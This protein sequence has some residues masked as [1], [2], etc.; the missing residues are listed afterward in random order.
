MEGNLL[1]PPPTFDLSLDFY[2][3]SSLCSC[4]WGLGDQGSALEAERRVQGQEISVGY[5]TSTM[6]G[7]KLPSASNF[8]VRKLSIHHV[9]M[10]ISACR[11]ERCM[12]GKSRLD[13]SSRTRAT[14]SLYDCGRITAT[15]PPSSFTWKQA[16]I[17]IAI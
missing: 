3:R 16:G 12:Y 13:A 10:C 4:R 1:M 6:E 5:N 15:Q 7:W 17:T 11:A 2:H 14:A 8:K 9:C